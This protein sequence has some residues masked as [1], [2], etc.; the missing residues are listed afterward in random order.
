[1]QYVTV[2]KR[3]EAHHFIIIVAEDK[4]EDMG[5]KFTL[6]DYL[7]MGYKPK[8]FHAQFLDGKA[9]EL[10]YIYSCIH[11]AI[12]C[13]KS[14][15]DFGGECMCIL[16]EDLTGLLQDFFTVKNILFINQ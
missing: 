1:M 15:I 16:Q 13:N 4:D 7:Q 6:D 12:S 11:L 3:N 14:L 10:T 8:E 9:Q 2:V 5:E